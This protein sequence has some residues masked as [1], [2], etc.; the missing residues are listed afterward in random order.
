MKPFEA[1]SCPL[2]RCVEST[3]PT[4]VPTDSQENKENVNSAPVAM[5]VSIEVDHQDSFQAVFKS[6]RG[7]QIVYREL[8]GETDGDADRSTDM[9][10]D[11]AS[12]PV[13][14]GHRKSPSVRP[15]VPPLREFPYRCTACSMVFQFF[16][17]LDQHTE[18]QHS[19]MKAFKYSCNLCPFVAKRKGEIKKHCTKKH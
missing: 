14:R 8:C 13:P 7:R 18:S 3:L 17:L 10:T 4:S 6:L 5:P 1:S 16:T 12:C 9:T 15:I 2:D 19:G 11:S